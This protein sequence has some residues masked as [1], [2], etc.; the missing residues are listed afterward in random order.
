MLSELLRSAP[1]VGGRGVQD[2]RPAPVVEGDEQ[3]DAVVGGGL[4]L[5]PVHP[6][7]ELRGDL[8]APP[9]EAHPD[10]LL[11]ELRRLAVDPLG[12]HRHQPIDLLLGPG[13]ILRG[14]GI[15]GELLDAELGGVAQTLLDDVRT[16]P[17][18][19]DDRQA[20]LLR[21]ATIPVGDDRDVVGW[22]RRSSGPGRS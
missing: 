12:E 11:V 9:D 15:H 22:H 21:P 17:V 1:V 14:E 20:S 7:D 10:A 13:P 4:R 6:L 18:A 16:R 19:F 2:L 3:G 5:G 8:L